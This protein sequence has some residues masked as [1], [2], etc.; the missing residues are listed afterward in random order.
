[1][2]VPLAT[3]ERRTFAGLRLLG[4]SRE[5]SSRQGKQ[6]RVFQA[7]YSARRMS[8][9]APRR[10]T[11]VRRLRRSF[12][13]PWRPLGR[14]FFLWCTLYMCKTDPATLQLPQQP[15]RGTLGGAFVELSRTL[16]PGLQATADL[17]QQS[18]KT[19]CPHRCAAGTKDRETPSKGLAEHRMCSAEVAEFSNPLQASTDAM[20]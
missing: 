1:M 5:F 7:A 13:A 16:I 3:S 17:T 15:P 12:F 6:E 2:A 18:N 14:L 10:D 11:E 20:H 8:S 19:V 9:L 4:G